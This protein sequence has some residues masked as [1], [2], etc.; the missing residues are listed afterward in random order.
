[1]DYLSVC[2][3]VHASVGSSVCPVH[4][5]N[6]GSD[7]DAVW[8]HRSDGSRDEVGTGVWGSVHG[9]G[10]FWSE[11]RRAIVTNGSLRRPVGDFRSDAALFPNYFRHADLLLLLACRR[12]GTIVDYNDDEASAAF[13]YQVE[14]LNR[15]TSTFKLSVLTARLDADDS[16][17]VGSACKC[18]IV[19]IYLTLFCVTSTATEQN[20]DRYS[21]P[22]W[23]CMMFYTWY[24][25]EGLVEWV[26]YYSLLGWTKQYNSLYTPQGPV[27]KLRII[28]Y[29][30]TNARSS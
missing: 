25:G 22:W 18:C 7:P 11:F 1:M 14:S 28:P 19:L 3:S 9:K 2:R 13:N 20:D 16:Y 17:A 30:G 26:T 12:V 15:K 27:Y 10:Y 21:G 5:K 6:G 23:L 4:W 24:S 8:R 29:Y